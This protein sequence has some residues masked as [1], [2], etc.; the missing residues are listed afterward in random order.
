MHTDCKLFF[1]AKYVLFVG[2]V[3][4]FANLLTYGVGYPVL[5]GVYKFARCV[6]TA[7]TNVS[8]HVM[9]DHVERATTVDTR[10]ETIA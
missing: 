7:M 9:T 3:R 10:L 2:L 6:L 1:A 8:Y 4:K 5:G